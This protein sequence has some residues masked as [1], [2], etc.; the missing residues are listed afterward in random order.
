[1]RWGFEPETSAVKD[2]EPAIGWAGIGKSRA[3]RN[4]KGNRRDRIKTTR[5]TLDD[6]WRGGIYGARGC[7]LHSSRLRAAYYEFGRDACEWFVFV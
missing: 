3:E 4:K 6:F 2:V 7:E 5:R 1:M